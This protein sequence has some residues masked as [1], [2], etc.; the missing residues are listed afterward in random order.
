MFTPIGGKRKGFKAVV[1]HNSFSFKLRSLLGYQ[2]H[3]G[4]SVMMMFFVCNKS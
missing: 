3:N 1:G 2:T 4:T